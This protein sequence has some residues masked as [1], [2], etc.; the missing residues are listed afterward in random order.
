[1]VWCLTRPWRLHGSSHRST[2]G[3]PSTPAVQT[4]EK[5]VATDDPFLRADKP[6]EN[7]YGI[8]V[9]EIYEFLPSPYE[10]L[11]HMSSFLCQLQ[12]IL[13][14][15]R[16]LFS[17]KSWGGRV[18]KAPLGW[19]HFATSPVPRDPHRLR[20]ASSPKDSVSRA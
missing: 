10:F 15:Q 16:L 19:C 9:C 1:M 12:N 8:N 2:V 13:W 3:R 4:G 7:S 11:H 18:P 14:H 17:Q 6:N 20:L 5:G